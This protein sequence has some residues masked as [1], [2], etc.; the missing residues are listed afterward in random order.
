MQVSAHEM[1]LTPDAGVSLGGGSTSAPDTDADL[2][3]HY[4]SGDGSE[5]AAVRG[6]STEASLEAPPVPAASCN[7]C[8]D[9]VCT[10]MEKWS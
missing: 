6:W 2:E 4:R 7:L 5:A 1:I 3:S 8:N 9:L 10:P